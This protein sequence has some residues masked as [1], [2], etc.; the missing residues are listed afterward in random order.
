LTRIIFV[1][2]MWRMRGRP[3][4]PKADVKGDVLRIRLTDADRALLDEAAKDRNLD[5]S[6]WARSE[7]LTLARKLTGKKAT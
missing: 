5:T 3:K 4:K 1:A 6:T 2:T 7:L